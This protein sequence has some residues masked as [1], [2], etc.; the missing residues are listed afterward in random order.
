MSESQIYRIQGWHEFTSRWL[1]EAV[2][3]QWERF[4]RLANGQAQTNRHSENAAPNNTVTLIPLFAGEESGKKKRKD[5]APDLPF[6]RLFFGLRPHQS[7]GTH[8]HLSNKQ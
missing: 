1:N 2:L 3:H 4:L 7:D 8:W 5:E 6:T